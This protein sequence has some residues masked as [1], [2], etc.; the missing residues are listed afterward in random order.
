V[1]PSRI[2]VPA[3]LAGLA[4]ILSCS[5]DPTVPGKPLPSSDRYDVQLESFFGGVEYSWGRSATDLYAGTNLLLHFDGATWALVEVP[6]EASSISGGWNLANGDI[7]C[8][9]SGRFYRYNG[10]V[11]DY[12]GMPDAR[13]DICGLPSGEIFVSSYRGQVHRYDGASWSTDSVATPDTY[14]T[15]VSATATNNVF[16]VGDYG[17]IAHFDGAAWRT[18]RVDSVL[19]MRDVWS[20][21]DGSAFLTYNLYYPG[22]D[23][24]DIGEILRYTGGDSL[25][26]VGP[27]GFTAQTLF[28]SGAHTYAAGR[29]DNGNAVY[30]H[31]GGAW[32][33]MALPS[34]VSAYD[35]DWGTA[36]GEV[37]A[38]SYSGLWKIDAHRSERLLGGD[39]AGQVSA[40]W[41]SP[42]GSVFAVG[43]GARK[44][45]GD[46][47]VDLN[48]QA[49]TA[50]PPYAVHGSGSNDVWAVGDE[51]ILHYDGHA[52][53]WLSSG[54]QQRLY[55]VWT[56]G[57]RVFAV[58]E[59]G[60]ILTRDGREWTQMQSHTQESL[61]SV[62]GWD[63]GAVAVGWYGTVVMFDGTE[64]RTQPPPVEWDLTDVIALGPGHM[65]AVGW[66]PWSLLEYANGAWTSHTIE[67][68]YSRGSYDYS[69]GLWATS[70]HDIYIAQDGGDIH[71]FDGQSWT[72]LP[73]VVLRAMGPIA[74]SPAGDVFAASNSALLR[75]RRR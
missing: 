72:R 3:V 48:K 50:Q 38:A 60:T 63:G 19:S 34:D 39:R 21:P 29:D 67:S 49:I 41:T 40:L 54:F 35:V 68:H 23:S 42:D 9:N 62:S 58:G 24:Y 70:L 7:V 25:V 52:W 71:H 31:D 37:F 45:D 2:L 66:N 10:S 15:A 44:F 5:D 4:A 33:R 30:D 27:G 61:L 8:W 46:R 59:G 56:D 69:T 47:W 1:T 75:Y 43:E 53:A 26:S 20:A 11:W 64:W 6:D 22:S 51:M 73:R 65:I 55:G 32:T 17:F 16:A 57:R 18:T 14:L 12:I 28:G 74:V 36:Q 13:R